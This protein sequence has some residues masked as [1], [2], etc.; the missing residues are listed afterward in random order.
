MRYERAVIA[1][2]GCDREVAEAILA[3]GEFKPSDN[4][5]DWL[6]SGIYFWEYGYDRAARFADEQKE[7]GKVTTPTVIGALIQL[8]NCFDLMDTRFTDELPDAFDMLK[9]IHDAT[10]RPLPSNSGKTPD[11]KLRRLD[12]AVL[13]LYLKAQERD[14]AD[15]RRFDTIRC[16]FLE[17]EPA[18]EGSGIYRQS[19]IQLAVRN[20]A[21][22]LGVSRP[23]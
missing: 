20:P 9:Q 1:Y 7:R 22:V 8:G 12:C 6:G 4:D 2:H 13:N 11:K 21:C 3:G 10:G 19:H 17:G 5:Y 14:A 18:F 23:R 16:G 15:P